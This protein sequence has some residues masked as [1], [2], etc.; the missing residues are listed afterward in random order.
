MLNKDSDKFLLPKKILIA[1]GNNGKFNELSQIIKPFKIDCVSAKDFAINEPDENGLTFAENSLIK[2]KYY[3][4]KSAM[5]ALADDSGLCIVDLDNKPGINSGRF[6][7]NPKTN[8]RDF[9]FAF[10]KIFEQLK[11]KNVN[12]DSRPRAFFV[13]NLTIYNP[14]DDS[15]ISF[16]GRV[17]GYISH[18]PRGEKGFGYDPIF[19]KDGMSQTFAEIDSNYKELISHRGEAAKKLINYLKTAL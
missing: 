11:S 12:F 2:S 1:T 15:H 4:K 13:C 7:I 19:V 6:A 16:E 14:F 5:V 3:A 18:P 10:D 17:D 8:K 9:T